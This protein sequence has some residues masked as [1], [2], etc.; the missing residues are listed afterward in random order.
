MATTWIKAVH[1]TNSGSIS[2][3][4]KSTVEYAANHDK[5][6]GGE[7]IA[8]FECSPETALSEF[9]LSKKLYE[10]Q[11]GRNQGK[12]DVIGYQIRQSFKPGVPFRAKK[13]EQPQRFAG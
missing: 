4:V 1:R 8:A 9:M 13:R 2:A 7:L 10:R 12:H 5:T 6:Q 11:T 3:A